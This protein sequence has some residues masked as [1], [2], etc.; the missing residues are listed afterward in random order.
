MSKDVGGWLNEYVG[1]ENIDKLIK[2]VDDIYLEYGGNPEVSYNSKFAEYMDYEC[3][4]HGLR[5]VK[6][7]VRHLGTEKSQEIMEK[8]M[9][10]LF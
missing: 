1:N 8:C 3:S 5:F 4:K 10:L 7:P 9:T 6:C 2:Y